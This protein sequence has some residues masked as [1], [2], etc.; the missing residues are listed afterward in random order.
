M[1]ISA[2]FGSLMKYRPT[3]SARPS[4]SAEKYSLMASCGEPL[5]PSAWRPDAWPITSCMSVR[6][7]PASVPCF[8]LRSDSSVVKENSLRMVFGVP[9]S[10]ASRTLLSVTDLLPC[11]SRMAWS[12]GRLMPIGVTGPESP[13]SITTSMALATMPFTIGLRNFASYGMWSSNHCALSAN[14]R[15]RSVFSRFT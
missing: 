14:L 4:S 12:F 8:K 13:V 7:S 3:R 5:K 1:P 15:M 10:L 2:S 6:S 11:A 9:L